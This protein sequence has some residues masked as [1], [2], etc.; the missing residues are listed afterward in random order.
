MTPELNIRFLQA[1]NAFMRLF[2]ISLL[3]FANHAFAEPN[4]LSLNCLENYKE[5]ANNKYEGP[6]DQWATSVG[7]YMARRGGKSKKQRK[8]KK[9]TVRRRNKSHRHKSYRHKKH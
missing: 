2:L 3:F 1:Y 6:G 5:L 8:Y 7:D 9:K 4:Y